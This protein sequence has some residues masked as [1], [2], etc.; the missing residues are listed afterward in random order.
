MILVSGGGGH[1]PGDHPGGIADGG[2]AGSCGHPVERGRVANDVADL[3]DKTLGGEIR[4]VDKLRGTGGDDGAGVE[5]LLPVAMRE[6]H[7]DGGD[8]LLCP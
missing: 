8:P 1:E 4:V 3:A 5:R 2:G 6:R 7:I